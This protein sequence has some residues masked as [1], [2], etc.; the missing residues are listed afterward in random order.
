MGGR[1]KQI[2]PQSAGPTRKETWSDPRGLSA[3]EKKA[4]KRARAEPAPPPIDDERFRW[5]GDAIDYEYDGSW[6]WD[7]TPKE[8]ADL[9]TLL[10]NLTQHSWR[11]VKS[12]TTNGHHLHHAQPT[13]SLCD[14]ARERLDQ[15]QRGDEEEVFRLRHGNRLRIWGVLNRA[16]FQIIWYDREHKVYPTEP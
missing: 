8:V 2:P 13:A 15:L 9:L 6:S 16:V 12:M 10:G 3:S 14:E 1:R 7:L 5:S 11:E 4:A